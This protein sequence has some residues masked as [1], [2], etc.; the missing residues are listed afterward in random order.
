VPA[1]VA[2]L[3]DQFPMAAVVVSR[4]QAML[5]ANPIARALS[6]GFEVGQSLSRWSFVDPAAKQVFPD[7]DEATA[8][9]V[10][11]LRQGSADDPD[12][13]D[14][15]H[16]STNCPV[17]A[18]DSSSSGKRPTWDTSRGSATCAIQMLGIYT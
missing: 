14:C 1:A 11:D 5:A 7:W 9:A 6:P 15:A 16:S 12:D 2:E 3:I 13:P 4:Y 10:R 17:P 18:S 8:L